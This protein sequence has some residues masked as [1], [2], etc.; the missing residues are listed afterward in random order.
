MQ[1]Y[2]NILEQ[3]DASEKE[4]KRIGREFRMLSRRFDILKNNHNSLISLNR[5]MAQEKIRQETYVE[6]L[7]RHCPDMIIMLDEELRFLTGT[8]SVS[9]VINVEDVSSLYGVKLTAILEQ[10]KPQIFT[11]EFL[12]EIS[13][14]KRER[15]GSRPPF[16]VVINNN[17]FE[18][19]VMPFLQNDESIGVLIIIH[20]ITELSESKNIAEQA[21]RAKGE[22]L[23]RMSH[24]MRTPM[25]AVVG[26][27][28]IALQSAESERKDYCLDKIEDAAT[29]LLGIINDILDLSKIEADMLELHKHPFDLRQSIEKTVGVLGVR[30]EEKRQDFTIDIDTAI[31]DVIVGDELRFTQVISNLLSNANKFTPKGGTISLNIVHF[32]SGDG[33]MLRVEVT[34]SGIGISPTQH[35]RMFSVFEQADGSTTREFGGSGLGL[36]ICKKIVTIMGGYIWI[37][38]ELGQGAKFIFTMPFEASSESMEAVA[39]DESIPDLTGRKILIAE[40]VDIN[41]EI[42]EAILDATGAKITF[43]ENGAEAVEEYQENFENIDMIF[44]DIQMPIM[45]G[46]EATRVIRSTKNRKAKTIP[47][48]AMTANVFREDVERC[49]AAGTNAHVGKPIDPTELFRVI[50]RYL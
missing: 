6:L 50:G 46:F 9:R 34:D 33:S 32:Q 15:D 49:L 40:D 4:R 30:M 16:E 14:A 29:H 21:S 3:L 17:I 31:P 7:M 44:M 2:D 25:N 5:S 26:M 1:D 24:E 13:L 43:A 41:R 11:V 23:S 36:P 38:S 8:N 12:K 19:T 10:Y 27:T 37:E 35:S 48:I 47:I 20:D 39:E 18:V 45:D 42:I 22:F 28:R